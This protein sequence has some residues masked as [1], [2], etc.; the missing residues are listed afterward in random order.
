M[1][2]EWIVAVSEGV[3]IFRGIK[4]WWDKRKANKEELIRAYDTLIKVL[5]KL[6]LVWE[7]K[8]IIRGIRPTPRERLNIL[9]DIAD[10]LMNLSL[11]VEFFDKKF[12]DDL[13]TI[14]QDFRRVASRT[15]TTMTFNDKIKE[16]GNPIIDKVK[17]LITYL[18]RNKVKLAEPKRKLKSPF[19]IG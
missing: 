2:I 13:L 5:K 6:L 4:G 11:E 3:S 8:I 14:S 18:E 9:D 16:R 10:N 17:E 1:V 7:N 15:T 19:R 12:S